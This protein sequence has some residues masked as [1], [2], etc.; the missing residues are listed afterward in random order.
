M[1][2]KGST[3]LTTKSKIEMLEAQLAEL[4][5]QMSSSAE[6]TPVSVS[7]ASDDTK[8][9]QDEYI[10]V[11]SLLP[12]NLNLSTREGGQGSIK[13]FSKFGEVKKILYKD[14]VDI[15]E[16]HSHF[17]ESG[18]FYIMDKRVIRQHGLDDTY[19]KLLTKE[20]IEEI[21]ATSSDEAVSLY[22][23]AN[24][25][26]QEIIIQLLIDKVK[27]SPDSVNLNIVDKISRLS[28]VDI[29]KRAEDMAELEP[30][31]DAVE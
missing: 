4:K 2:T 14:L 16:V 1:T 22:A 25:G 30:K 19:A 13:K 6:E 20:K 5:A 27:T 10:P 9:Q 26:Q 7:E 17:V 28:K 31:K 15:L 23:S 11:M 12:Y 8:I 3:K 29:V 24:E 21:L 18:Y